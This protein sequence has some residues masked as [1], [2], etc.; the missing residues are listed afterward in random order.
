[1][2]QDTARLAI[3]LEV[4]ENLFAELFGMVYKILDLSPDAVAQL[5]KA[6]LE[7]VRAEQIPTDDPAISD[8]VPAEIEEDYEQL[9]QKIEYFSQM[10]K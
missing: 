4:A 7:R 10:P 6:I 5:H 2:D 1:M 9:L 8:H 3:K